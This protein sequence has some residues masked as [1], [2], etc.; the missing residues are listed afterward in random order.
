MANNQKLSP[1][2]YNIKDEPVNQ[3]PLWEEMF[4][5]PAGGNTGQ[6]LTKRTDADYDTYWADVTSGEGG[7]TIEQVR[8]ITDPLENR[9][10]SLETEYVELTGTTIP[11]L[12]ARVK[13]LEDSPPSGVTIEQ[14]NEA[15]DTA[16]EP[17]NDE[18]AT[19]SAQ[20]ET[21]QEEINKNTSDISSLD[22]RVTNIN[23]YAENIYNEL[24][25][26]TTI[27]ESRADEDS[28]KI[29]D[30]TG[31]VTQNEQALFTLND[32][33]TKVETAL[34]GGT[35]NQILAKAS[36][37]N[38]D[39]KWVD[40]AQGGGVTLEQVHAITD[41]IETKANNNANNITALETDVASNSERIDGLVLSNNTL[42]S[43]V[44]EVE[45]SVG[46]L[47]TNVE[48]L[49]T[50]VNQHDGQI[51]A[52]SEAVSNLSTSLSG[53]QSDLSS[54]T[55][56]FNAV[57]TALNGQGTTGQVLTRTGTG[58]NAFGWAEPS[59][60]GGVASPI[61]AITR[62]G[63]SWNI[64]GVTDNGATEIVDTM[65]TP[66]TGTTRGNSQTVN[67]TVTHGKTAA[68][69]AA[70]YKAMY[71]NPTFRISLDSGQAFNFSY[72][73]WLPYHYVSTDNS[74]EGF[75]F[76]EIGGGCLFRITGNGSGVIG[77]Y[78]DW[79]FY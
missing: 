30:L 20:Y 75:A 3:N 34:N 62:W 56:D 23:G 50:E 65:S 6:V 40:P 44:S 29:S 76:Q 10:V 73:I 78:L 48:N 12:D 59:G 77:T 28:E 37:T 66:N 54:L 7:V 79:R 53:T 39:F 17:V 60:G 71:I 72:I 16:L 46:T 35:T 33:L 43:R 22:T 51:T 36:G 24:N 11:A 52:N 42:T 15:I 70:Q 25:G 13:A 18:L 58:N 74:G 14:V 4:G 27:L 69:L 9:V 5:V 19:L 31:R 55:G 47:S 26:R 67:F 41:P 68:E 49:Q 32:D 63:G 57:N 45:G 8:A 38:R 21:Q 1:Q 61:T 2:G 64:Y